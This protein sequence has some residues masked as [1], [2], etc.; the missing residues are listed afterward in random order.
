MQRSINDIYTTIVTL[1]EQ[2]DGL[3]PADPLRQRLERERDDLRSEAA[4]YAI[5]GRHPRSVKLEIEAIEQRL[6]EIRSLLITEGYAEKRSG[7]NIQDPGAYSATINRILNEQHADE[8]RTL[9][10]QLERLRP[11]E[12]DDI[13]QLRDP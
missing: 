6:S 5:D 13:E 7:R 2:I 8:V 9:T 1:S 11:S 4:T 3:P 10:E 12:G